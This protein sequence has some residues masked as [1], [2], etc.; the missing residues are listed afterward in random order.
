RRAVC[1]LSLGAVP[2]P[3]DE[4]HRSMGLREACDLVVDQ[5]RSKTG[6]DEV[7]VAQR[8][9]AALGPNHPDGAVGLDPGLRLFQLLEIAHLLSSDEDDVTWRSRLAPDDF[10]RPRSQQLHERIVEDANDRY[11]RARFHAELVEQRSR[12]RDVRAQPRVS[13]LP[14]RIAPK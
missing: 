14:P 10:W 5:P 7:G 3:K 2:Q 4:T 12:R 1:E 11:L 9:A 8:A 6:V 13:S